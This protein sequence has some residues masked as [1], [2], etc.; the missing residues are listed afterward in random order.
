[1]AGGFQ[2]SDWLSLTTAPPKDEGAFLPLSPDPRL[3]MGESGPHWGLGVACSEKRAGEMQE[4]NPR[5]FSA[6]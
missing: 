2:G 5:M 6:H 1:V 3:R 4:S